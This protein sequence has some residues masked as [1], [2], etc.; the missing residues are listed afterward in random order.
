[1]MKVSATYHGARYEDTDPKDLSCGP[2]M[3]APS[4]RLNMCSI[5]GKLGVSSVYGKLEMA[6]IGLDSVTISLP[7]K[8]ELESLTGRKAVNLP[9]DVWLRQAFACVAVLHRPGEEPWALVLNLY[10][11]KL[12]MERID[13]GLP[14]H[15]KQAQAIRS[16]IIRLAKEHR[17]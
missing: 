8:K 5:Y 17:S 3:N 13:P 4:T 15:L 10:A 2:R 1:M 6:S 9:A 14:P 16:L 7:G 12:E 11:V